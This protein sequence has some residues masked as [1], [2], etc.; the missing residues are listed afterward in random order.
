MT[1]L[2]ANGGRSERG[3]RM[4]V[5]EQTGIARVRL[6]PCVGGADVMRQLGL[7]RI[8]EARPEGGLTGCHHAARRALARRPLVRVRESGGHGRP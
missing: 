8:G 6:V 4:H 1:R 2:T 7:W 3:S 5:E